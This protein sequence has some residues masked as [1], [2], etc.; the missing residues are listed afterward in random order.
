MARR[1]LG[2][3]AKQLRATAN[4]SNR[5]IVSRIGR[6]RGTPCMVG[7]K[8]RAP[9]AA[10][11]GRGLGR[12]KLLPSRA[13]AEYRARNAQP[14]VVRARQIEEALAAGLNLCDPRPAFR[15]VILRCDAHAIQEGLALAAAGE[16]RLAAARQAAARIG[17]AAVANADPAGR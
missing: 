11:G 3:Y 8:L 16:S 6:I 14:V 9:A 12:R 1:E 2:R 7:L 10:L 15:L 13:D 4:L 5:E 17:P